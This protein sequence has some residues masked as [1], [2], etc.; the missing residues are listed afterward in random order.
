MSSLDALTKSPIE[1]EVVPTPA[2]RLDGVGVRY[3]V[4]L[5]RGVSLKEYVVRRRGD[6]RTIEHEAL[7]E[8][9]LTIGKGETLGII[10]P[11]GAGKSTLLKVIA[12]VLHPSSGR[13]RISGSVA[14]LIDLFGAFHPELTGRE[15][16]FLNGA[17]LGIDYRNMQSRIASIAAFA[18]IGEFFDAPLRSYSAGMMVRLAFSVATS[19]DADILLVDEALGVGDAAFQQKCSDRMAEFRRQGVTFVVVSHDVLRLVEMCSRIVWLES[20]RIVEIG[21]SNEVVSHY[22]A[23]LQR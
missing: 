15:N 19:I 4:S 5:D 23:T 6:R 17:L 7:R 1:P 3:R 20:G 22:L 13:L 10:G 2:V 8:V 12:R 16:A 11:N 21:P 14:P 9:S 18:E